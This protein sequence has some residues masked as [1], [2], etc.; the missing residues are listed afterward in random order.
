MDPLSLTSR[1]VP[2]VPRGIDVAGP[3]DQADDLGSHLARSLQ[4]KVK[5]SVEI[6]LC[7]Q[8]SEE[9]AGSSQAAGKHWLLHL[10]ST[11]PH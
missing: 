4:M 1:A 11:T 6:M 10:Q 2:N 9:M 5:P 8:R 3:V 7:A